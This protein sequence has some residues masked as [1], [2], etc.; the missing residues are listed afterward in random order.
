MS[1]PSLIPPTDRKD[2]F[3]NFKPKVL[4]LVNLKSCY[5]RIFKVHPIFAKNRRISVVEDKAEG[6][7]A[8]RC[9]RLRQRHTG[10]LTPQLLSDDI[11]VADSVVVYAG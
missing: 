2:S 10:M 1:I 6:K 9:R 8:A 4:S 7:A 11:I 3:Q 5:T